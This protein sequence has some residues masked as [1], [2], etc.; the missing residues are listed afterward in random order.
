MGKNTGTKP[1]LVRGISDEVWEEYRLACE[2]LYGTDN[3]SEVIRQHVEGTVA[4]Y[5]E[6]LAKRAGDV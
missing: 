3:R 4:E 5:R 1:R 2:A 6:L